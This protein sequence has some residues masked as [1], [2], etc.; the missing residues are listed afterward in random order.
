[1][2]IVNPRNVNGTY[3]SPS[4]HVP[5]NMSGTFRLQ[6]QILAS[7]FTDPTK[8]LDCDIQISDTGTAGTWKP[9]MGFGWVGGARLDMH[10]QP[11]L[12]SPGLVI[13]DC[14]LL[15]N[16]YVRCVIK[17]NSRVNIGATGIYQ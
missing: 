13:E 4:I 7:D 12:E 8:K 11:D 6:S 1:M 2:F 10:G 15:S 16:K 5:T 3:T 14:S 9:F 17:T